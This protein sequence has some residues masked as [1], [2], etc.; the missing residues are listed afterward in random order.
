MAARWAGAENG[1]LRSLGAMYQPRGSLIIR[2]ASSS[3]QPGYFRISLRTRTFSSALVFVIFVTV[4][5]SK[6]SYDSC[7]EDRTNDGRS[8]TVIPSEASESA[9]P[10]R[11]RALSQYSWRLLVRFRRR[12]PS[13]EPLPAAN[14]DDCWDQRELVPRRSRRYSDKCPVAQLRCVRPYRCSKARIGRSPSTQP[15]ASERGIG[16]GRLPR[17]R[18]CR[19]GPRRSWCPGALP[20]QV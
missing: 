16:N 9:C 12:I 20:L 13:N 15:L 1:A 10:Q 2:M 3:S 18:S 4:F 7:D 8:E 19:R 17:Q 6:I 11:V 14:A 5:I